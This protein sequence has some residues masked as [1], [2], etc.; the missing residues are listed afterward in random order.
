MA[1]KNVNKRLNFLRKKISNTLVLIGTRTKADIISK[2]LS[3]RG[4]DGKKFSSLTTVYKKWKV[5]KGR[6]GVADM[7]FTGNMA[8]SMLVK[9]KGNR[10][11]VLTFSGNEMPKAR[12]NY[13]NRKNMMTLSD[14]WKK[15]MIILA[16][17]KMQGVL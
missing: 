17:R 4:A 2:W 11:A 15:K 7:F 13:S 9:K 14:I 3:G 1:L 5:K 6:K 16:L 12:G 10:Q 8:A